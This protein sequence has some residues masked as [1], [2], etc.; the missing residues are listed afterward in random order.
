MKKVFLVVFLI[1]GTVIGSGFST[2]K[3]IVVFFSRFGY[4]SF[5]FIPLAFVLFYFTFY[6][7]MTKGLKQINNR[8]NS[9]IVSILMLICATIFSSSMFAGIENCALSANIIFQVILIFLILVLCFFSC[10]KKLNF[11]SVINLVLIPIL[12]AILLG[13]FIYQFPQSSFVSFNNP[14]VLVGLFGGGF[15]LVLYVVL[16]VS[17]SSVVIAKSGEGLT[18]KQ[19]RLASFIS[20]FVLSVFIL[21][22]N[23]LV[24]CNYDLINSAMPLLA[25]SD[26]KFT[27]L[28]R[29]VIM[30]G[31]LTTL[32]SMIYV[33][34]SSCKEL[35]IGDR[36]IFIICVILPYLLSKIG[37]S[38][39][40]SFLYP[41]AS[42][43]GIFLLFLLFFRKIT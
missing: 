35:K 14:S 37:F 10:Y 42:Y 20:A 31:C 40:V 43:L 41:L 29:F 34:S 27:F 36:N 21:L 3:E 8:K 6:F 15:Y 39:I 25:L 12:L 24:V 19:I 1:L 7:L 13:F 30:V 11:L 16:N 17:L 23:I 4:Y 38:S 2:G 32:L 9:K 33:A 26:G 18:K 22:I 28:L 5:L